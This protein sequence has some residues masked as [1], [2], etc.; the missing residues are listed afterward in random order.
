MERNLDNL[1]NDPIE[2][3]KQLAE[4]NDAGQSSLGKSIAGTLALLESREE[5]D[6]FCDAMRE[7]MKEPA[8]FKD[9]PPNSELIDGCETVSAIVPRFQVKKLLLIAELRAELTEALFSRLSP[10]EARRLR[11]IKA[12]LDAARELTIDGAPKNLLDPFRERDGT[13]GR[14]AVVTARPLA[15]LELGPNLKAF[16]AAMRAVPVK[17]RLVDAAGGNVIFS[18]LLE[19]IDREGP[20]TTLLSFLG[21]FAL[22]LLYFRDWRT[23]SEIIVALVVGVVLMGGIAAALDLKINFF[24]FIVYPIT[25]G[26]AVDYGAN[27]GARVRE[28]GGKVL[29][30]LVEV[31]PAVILC[32]W[33]TVIGYGSLLLS[34]NR[35]LRSFGWYGMLGEA[36]TLL[37]ALVLL[38][39]LM[40]RKAERR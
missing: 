25:F 30:S 6:L 9:A 32:S 15:R 14:L 12:D 28:R 23:S 10:D 21:V 20:R 27:V 38:P 13:V 26:I 34:L 22:V 31:G 24:N 8:K 19:N 4:D 3:N 29:E 39:A 35:A 33:T 5:A 2:Q 1:G 37:T 17:G 11:G 40:L 36:T 18:D 7:R 16:V